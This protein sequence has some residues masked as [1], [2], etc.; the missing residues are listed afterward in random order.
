MNQ[1]ESVSQSF[2]FNHISNE[3]V[4]ERWCERERFREEN[5]WFRLKLHSLFETTS[6]IM[7][8]DRERIKSW[9]LVQVLITRPSL[10][11]SKVSRQHLNSCLN[12]Q[13]FYPYTF[14]SWIHV[15]CSMIWLHFLLQTWMSRRCCMWSLH[16]IPHW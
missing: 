13:L 9:R 6:Q 12:N 15:V 10:T 1:L 3:R 8:I 14:L 16:L 2:W 7:I 4:T 5:T 11:K